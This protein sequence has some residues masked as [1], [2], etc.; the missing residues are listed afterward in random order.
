MQRRISDSD[1]TGAK[2]LGSS[3]KAKS[4]PDALKD[5][6]TR[7]A[8][9]AAWIVDRYLGTGA[10]GEPRRRSIRRSIG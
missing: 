8:Q 3:T 9:K 7:S 2:I 5:E 6:L 4:S 10:M 1:K